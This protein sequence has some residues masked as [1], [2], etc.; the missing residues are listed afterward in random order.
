MIDMDSKPIGGVYAGP[1]VSVA[2]SKEGGSVT[3]DEENKTSDKEVNEEQGLDQAGQ[4]VTE[5]NRVANSVNISVKLDVDVNHAEMAADGDVADANQVEGLESR[6]G[7]AIRA[8]LASEEDLTASQVF[9]LYLFS[10][11]SD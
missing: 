4:D 5:D 9:F 1:A 11:Y 10:R 3:F 2:F 6:D 8:P 7:G